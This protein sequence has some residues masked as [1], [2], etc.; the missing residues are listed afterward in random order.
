MSPLTTPVKEP[1]RV[2]MGCPARLAWLATLMIIGALPTVMEEVTGGGWGVGG[3]AGLG[4]GYGDG[5][6]AGDGNC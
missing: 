5:S 6:G 2:G 1:V 4:G 3:V